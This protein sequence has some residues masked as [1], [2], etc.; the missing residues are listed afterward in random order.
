[1]DEIP[2]LKRHLEIINNNTIK[3]HELTSQLLD[4]R[5]S[6]IDQ[7]HLQFVEMDMCTLVK[8]SWAEYLPLL[9]KRNILAI[10]ECQKTEI[11]L[12]GNKDALQKIVNNLI[13]NAIKYCQH[14]IVLKLDMDSGQNFVSMTIENDGVVIP[15]EKR[16]TIFE[17]F[18]RYHSDIPGSGIGLSFAYLLVQLHKG[19]LQYVPENGLNKFELRLPLK[20][21]I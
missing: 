4:F 13:D 9:E 5:K 8:Q 17:P 16:V 21:S 2:H 10:L 7:Y 1:M 20:Q 12:E 18:S 3:L 6:E 15:E 19:V 11:K 14:S